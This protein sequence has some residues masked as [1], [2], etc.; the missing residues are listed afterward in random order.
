MLL[1]SNVRLPR[2]NSKDIEDKRRLKAE[3]ERE[4]F[5]EIVKDMAND[6]DLTSLSYKILVNVGILLDADRCSL[7]L[8][9]GPKG[10]RELVSK[11]FDVHAGTNVMPGYVGDNVVRIPWGMGIIGYVAEHGVQLNVPDAYQDSRFCDEVDKSTGYRT[12]SILCMPIKDS[13][14]EVIGVAQAINKNPDGMPFDEED[15]KVFATYLPFCGIGITNA[16]LFDISMREQERNRIWRTKWSYLVPAIDHNYEVV[17]QDEIL[18][19]PQTGDQTS[20]GTPP[21]PAGNNIADPLGN[22]IHD[23]GPPQQKK[24]GG[25]RC[26]NGY[27]LL[28]GTCIS[29][30]TAPWGNWLFGKS[31]DGAKEAC[32]K[33]G[34]T[35]A[36]PKT[37]VLDV[38]LRD[39]VKTEGGNKEHWIGMEEKE[40]T[41]YWIDGSKV[42]NNGYK[43][44]NPGEPGGWS[45]GQYWAKS[46][47]WLSSGSGY[48]M[49]DDDACFKK[50]RFICQRPPA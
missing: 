15:V 24:D 13:E 34:A 41:W 1:K 32:R 47:S 3:N 30:V 10:R 35:L 29:L 37:E 6:L 9:E 39:L 44:W 48:P 45:C 2:V 27:K 22:A 8:V 16:K 43:G 36:M 14:G 17:E 49:W 38:A 11:V 25:P 26:K 40:G 42:G 21:V 50:K 12:R 18:N 46:S 28:A 5:L 33:E 31:H 23:P 4:F 7:F 19:E 20:A